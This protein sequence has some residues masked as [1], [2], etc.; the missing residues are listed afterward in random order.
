LLRLFSQPRR[1]AANA[2]LEYGRAQCLPLVGGLV[3]VTTVLIFV[4]FA[5]N[6]PE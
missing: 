5:I 4:S 6:P 1:S 3:V 2:L